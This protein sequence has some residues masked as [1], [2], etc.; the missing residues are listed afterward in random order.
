MSEQGG[1]SFAAMGDVPVD[2]YY[3]MVGVSRALPTLRKLGVSA[4]LVG[5]EK[6]WRLVD[7]PKDET[8][9]LGEAVKAA[10][11]E[12][13]PNIEYVERLG[14]PF[15]LCNT[16]ELAED[17]WHLFAAERREML[18]R[19][20]V[21]FFAQLLHPFGTVAGDF[22][23][24]QDKGFST[25]ALAGMKNGVALSSGAM[26]PLTDERGVRQ[27]DF[28]FTAVGVSSF[29]YPQ[30]AAGRDNPPKAPLNRPT[31]VVSVKKDCVVFGRHA[32][33]VGEKFGD[34]W[35][36]P[37]DG[38]GALSYETRAP[39]F[40]APQF[41]PDAKPRID[42]A[43]GKAADGSPGIE[44]VKVTFPRAASGRAF[45]YE[46]TVHSTHESDIDVIVTQRRFYSPGVFL[47]PSEEPGTVSCQIDKSELYHDVLLDFEVR[48]LDS[49]GHKGAPIVASR[50]IPGDPPPEKRK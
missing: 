5:G 39:G 1:L 4:V 16:R 44:R 47:P 12:K 23:S 34:D 32:L 7:I 19:A 30:L 14:V 24:R 18:A 26:F 45:E 27:G 21:F 46:I 42:M 31:L 11:A 28:G 22:V 8:F 10:F 35:V 40:E 17:D 6:E 20:K 41:A 50:K 13:K 37:L 3:C 29:R 15:V 25:Q 48:A 43:R 9:D 36:M 2:N 49:F 38:Y 33:A